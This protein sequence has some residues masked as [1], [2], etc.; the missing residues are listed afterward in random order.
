[1]DCE[2][3]LGYNWDE[4]VTKLE[5]LEEL[6]EKLKVVAPKADEAWL[7]YMTWFW[8]GDAYIPGFVRSLIVEYR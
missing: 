4:F 8:Q 3:K 2:D 6:V 7:D 1:M 5:N